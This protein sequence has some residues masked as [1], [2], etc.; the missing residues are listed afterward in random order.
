MDPWPRAPRQV[1]NSRDVIG[2]AQKL[3]E[4]VIKTVEGAR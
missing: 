2:F 4:V 1:D 3:E